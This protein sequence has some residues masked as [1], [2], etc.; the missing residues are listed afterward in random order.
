MSDEFILLKNALR[1]ANKMGSFELE[2][3]AQI[4]HCLQVVEG[5]LN[6]KK[7]SE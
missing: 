5:Q 3:S 7:E 6:D 2:E 4:L 1:K